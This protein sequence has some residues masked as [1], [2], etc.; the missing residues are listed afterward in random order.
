MSQTSS[1]PTLVD[2]YGRVLDYLRLSVTD[3]CNL[4][5]RYC[6]P[7]AGVPPLGHDQVLSYE[8]LLRLA[9]I[10]CELGVRKVRVTGGEPLVRRGIVDFIGALSSLPQRPEVVLTTNGLRLAE[11]A[12]PLKDAGLRRVN[13]SLDTLRAERFFDI[14]RRHGLEEVLAGLCEAEQVGLG[15]VKINMVPIA[16]V[17]DDE[18]ADF[19][20]L[21]LKYP[22]DVRFIEFMPVSGDLDYSP[23][24]RVPADSIMERL[25]ALGPLTEAS[26]SASAGPARLYRLPGGQALVGVIP[27]VSNHFCGECN[28]LRITSAGKLRPCL[29]SADE[30]DLRQ[31]LRA[32]GSDAELAELFVGAVRIKPEG[33]GLDQNPLGPGDKRMQEI[34]G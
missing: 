15:P 32:G 5:C 12:R 29:F 28:R 19:A 31:V 27:A 13:V 16:G 33:H 6:M 17:N 21:T 23:E 7:E 18:I 10:A 25:T 9:R 14:T 8:E 34:G 2:T 30:I 20:E 22:W 3:R 1:K 11:L 4:R 26:R 24:Q